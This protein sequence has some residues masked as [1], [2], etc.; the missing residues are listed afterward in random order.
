MKTPRSCKPIWIISFDP[1]LPGK[2]IKEKA[3]FCTR[4]P[5]NTPSAIDPT[6]QLAIEFLERISSSF[7][8]ISEEFIQ[9]TPLNADGQEQAKLIEEKFKSLDLWLKWLK[10]WQEENP[11]EKNP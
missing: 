8:E 4:L 6:D 1:N 2:T 10:K 9:S 5:Q 3:L 7:K 11:E